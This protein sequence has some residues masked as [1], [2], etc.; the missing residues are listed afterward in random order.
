[1]NTF[2]KRFVISFGLVIAVVACTKALTDQEPPPGDPE[3]VAYLD[4]QWGIR[5]T[6]VS[7]SES[8]TE[9]GGASFSF[10]VVETEVDGH[11]MRELEVEEVVPDSP[12]E[13][14]E[15]MV[16]DVLTGEE[17][18]FIYNTADNYIAIANEEEQRGVYVSGNTDGTYEV[19]TYDDIA[20]EEDRQ[21]VADGYAA[22]R[23]VEEYNSFKDAP[24]HVLLTAF[25]YGHTQPPEART[26]S[27]CENT[28]A[29]PAACTI[30]QEF[31]DCAACLVLDREGSCDPC[32]EL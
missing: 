24:P 18:F 9:Q 8:G 21:T 30:F 11:G 2:L 25:A 20:G 26:L 3:L 14:S 19:W 17:R 6:R 10:R 27:V 31:C 28:A 7:Y 1:M 23:L 15:I 22:L 32:P 12:D 29:P 5:I 4:E 16:A 13:E